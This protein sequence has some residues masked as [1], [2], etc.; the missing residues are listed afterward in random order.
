M[1]VQPIY[2]KA[3]SVLLMN[4]ESLTSIEKKLELPEELQAPIKEK[5]VLGTLSYYHGS[6]KL[7]EVNILAESAVEAAKYSD[8]VKRVWLAWMM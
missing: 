3:F 8:Y 7:G 6:K 5:Q 1:T 4:G 2:E